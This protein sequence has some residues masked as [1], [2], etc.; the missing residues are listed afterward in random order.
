MVA[1]LDV[2]SER[3]DNGCDHVS[4]TEV[5]VHLFKVFFPLRNVIESYLC[6]LRTNQNLSLCSYV[7]EWG[8]CRVRLQ[9]RSWREGAEGS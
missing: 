1:R 3:C 5:R 6:A 8:F 7:V 9:S 2:N 4:S